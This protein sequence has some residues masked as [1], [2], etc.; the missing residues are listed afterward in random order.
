MAD[1]LRHGKINLYFQCNFF[2]LK[3]LL[4]IKRCR[5]YH[6]CPRKQQGAFATAGSFLG[7]KNH[8]ENRVA[9]IL[10]LFFHNI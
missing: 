5:E 1:V 10:K 4:F 2:I 3:I 9:M 7:R 8:P 6:A